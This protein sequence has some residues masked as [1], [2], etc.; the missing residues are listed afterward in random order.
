MRGPTN[1]KIARIDAVTWQVTHPHE[2]ES[3]SARDAC[4]ILA[5]A[6]HIG[7]GDAVDWI[8][9]DLYV[10]RNERGARTL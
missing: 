7:S 5:D 6:G 2:T 4:D 3:Y 1:A 9:S 10:V 8:G